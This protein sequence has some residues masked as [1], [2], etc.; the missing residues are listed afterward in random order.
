MG[1]KLEAHP[2]IPPC[3]KRQ[4]TKEKRRER[5]VVNE[6]GTTGSIHMECPEWENPI[7]QEDWFARRAGEKG[8]RKVTANVYEEPLCDGNISEPDTGSGRT[9]R[10]A[11]TQLPGYFKWRYVSLTSLMINKWK[12]NRT[13]VPTQLRMAQPRAPPEKDT[14]NHTNVAPSRR[15]LP[16][17]V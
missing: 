16:G 3:R 8:E 17:E 6:P 2:F 9:A 15:Q 10:I 13:A 11:L 4:G 7:R 1:Q 12:N 14:I 5:H